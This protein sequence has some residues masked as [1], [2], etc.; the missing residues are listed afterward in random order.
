VLVL[1]RFHIDVSLWEAGYKIYKKKTI[2]KFLGVLVMATPL[3]Y[4]LRSLPVLADTA[5]TQGQ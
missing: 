5:E 2:K 1:L 4:G 3:G